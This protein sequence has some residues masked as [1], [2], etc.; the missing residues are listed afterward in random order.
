MWRLE[1]RERCDVGG[2]RIDSLTERG[3]E[4]GKENDSEPGRQ[5]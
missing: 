2:D 4:W 5:V 1:S 3:K